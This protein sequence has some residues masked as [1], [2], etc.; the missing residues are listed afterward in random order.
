MSE[1]VNDKYRELWDTADEHLVRYRGD[2][3]SL[4][5]ERA[6]GIYLY[7][8]DGR[9]ILDFSLGQICAT[10]G[11]NQ[12]TVVEALKRVGEKVIHPYVD[13]GTGGACG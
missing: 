13:P 12:P 7:D 5:V 4:V 6:E 11:H 1:G 9:A 3:Y 2:F 8:Q 10:L